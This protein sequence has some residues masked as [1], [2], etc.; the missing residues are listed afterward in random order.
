M[1]NSIPVQVQQQILSLQFDLQYFQRRAAEAQQNIS[2]ILNQLKLETVQIAVL[3]PAPVVQP[4]PGTRA[5]LNLVPREAP[6]QLLEV[7]EFPQTNAP[8]VPG[9][10][11]APE[12]IS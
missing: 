6:V 3:P 7:G 5:E 8:R 1:D 4:D 12:G 10:E 2:A 11:L 9:G